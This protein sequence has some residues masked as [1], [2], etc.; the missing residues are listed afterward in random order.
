MPF[1]SQTDTP[2]IQFEQEGRR[3]ENTD[4]VVVEIKVN[5]ELLR[6]CCIF[7][8]DVGGLVCGAVFE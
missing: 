2:D 7:E 3:T 1:L 6:C 8:G 5:L 4:I